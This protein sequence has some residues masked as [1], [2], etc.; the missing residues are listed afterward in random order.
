MN[1][2]AKATIIVRPPDSIYQ[3]GGRVDNGTFT[4]RWHFSFEQYYD[5]DYSHFGTLRVLNDDVLSPGAAWPL[6]PHR[7]IELVTYCACGACRH[8]DEQGRGGILKQGWVQHTSVGKGMVHAESNDRSDKPMR[9]IQMWFLPS[10]PDLEPAVQQRPVELAE[11]TNVLLPLV[12]NEHRGALPIV[13]DAKVFS[14][15]LEKGKH[16]DHHLTIGHGGYLYVLEGGPVEVDHESIPELGAAKIIGGGSDIS[17]KSDGDS[18]IL[19]IEVPLAVSNR[20]G[21]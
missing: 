2:S 19:F 8:A 21:I 6:H 10:E 15:H 14:S 17:I 13:S 3:S 12:S 4:G 9:F 11:R 18:E 7:N 20:M 1:K 5:R 16:L